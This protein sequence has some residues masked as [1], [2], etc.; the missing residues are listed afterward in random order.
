MQFTKAIIALL[1]V[2]S[3]VSAGCYEHG[4]SGNNGKDLK[5]RQLIRLTCKNLAGGYYGDEERGTCVV[6]DANV[7]WNFYF[8]NTDSKHQTLGEDYCVTRLEDR[9]YNCANGGKLTKDKW[10]AISDP[11]RGNCIGTTQKRFVQF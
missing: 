4:V 9:A 1:S 6:D 7:K 8:K 5:T 10:E 2:A 3:G 11:N